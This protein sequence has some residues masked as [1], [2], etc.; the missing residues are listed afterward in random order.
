MEGILSFI[1][2]FFSAFWLILK[3][4]VDVLFVTAKAILYMFFDGFLFVVTNLISTLDLSALAFTEYA[5]WND[6]PPQLIY[7]IN[8]LAL[9]QGAALIAGA[10]VI[11]LILNIIP[12]SLTRV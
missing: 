11:R 10:L 1:N 12:A 5:K 6:L 7:L 9:P 8:Q 4:G 2:S 3:L